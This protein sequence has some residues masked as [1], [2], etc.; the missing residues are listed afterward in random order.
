MSVKT[1]GTILAGIAG[2][3]VLYYLANKGTEISKL[4]NALGGT[5]IQ[6][7]AVLQGRNVKGVT[8]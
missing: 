7:I 8:N 1:F 5:G 6:A 4:V 2:L 3:I